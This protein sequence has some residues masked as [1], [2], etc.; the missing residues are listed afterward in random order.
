MPM[1]VEVKIIPFGQVRLEMGK[2]TTPIDEW[3]EITVREAIYYCEP[4]ETASRIYK[5]QYGGKLTY[6][7]VPLSTG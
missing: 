4:K 7:I 1:N 3:Q 6:Y 2:P 5:V